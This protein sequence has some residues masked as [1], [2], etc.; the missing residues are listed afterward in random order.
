VNVPAELSSV[1][2]AGDAKVLRTQVE[3]P[4]LAM[5]RNGPKAQFVFEQLLLLP[6]CADVRA[7]TVQLAPAQ[8]ASICVSALSGVGPSATVDWPPPTFRPPQVRFLR[9][10]PREP[11]ERTEPQRPLGVP[12]RKRST[13]GSDVLV[14]ELVVVLV[15]VDV[16]LLVLVLLVVARL[17]LV[18]LVVATLV[19]VVLEVLLLVEV[20]LLVL[21]LV[22]VAR[23]VL[24]VFDVDV[25]V[26]VVLLLDVVELFDVVVVVTVVGGPL[27]QS[28]SEL[29]TAPN[30]MNCPGWSFF[31]VEASK[32]AQ[33]RS[34]PVVMRISASP[35]VPAREM[36]VSLPTILRT[37]PSFNTTTLIG[38]GPA[39]ASLLMYL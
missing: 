31:T 26:D 25:L 10:V 32:K 23:L 36:P 18:L 30:A 16:E 7:D 12:V 15:L 39:G 17:V 1:P 28:V 38:T 21:L 6:V 35:V 8:V 33:L 20:V 14:V 13:R 11:P 4:A 9:M 37:L 3:V 19:L 24:V 29:A 34:V 27:E 2:V 22:V 5:G